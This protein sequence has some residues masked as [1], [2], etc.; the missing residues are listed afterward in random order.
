ME[1]LGLQAKH[2]GIWQNEFFFLF[3][4]FIFLNELTAEMGK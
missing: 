2:T 1:K 4:K 3:N